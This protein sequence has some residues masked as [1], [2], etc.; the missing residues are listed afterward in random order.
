MK[1]H[2]NPDKFLE[3][4]RALPI[5]QEMT[6]STVEPSEGVKHDSG[7]PQLSLV[8]LESLSGEARAME[9]GLRKYGRNN[10]KQGMAWSRLLDAALRHVTQFAGGEDNAPDSKLNHLYHAKANLGMLIYYYERKLGKDDR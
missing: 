3:Q 7:K 5:S 6:V 8:S 1:P 9:D 2:L 10:Y 4:M